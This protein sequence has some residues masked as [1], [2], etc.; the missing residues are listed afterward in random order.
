MNMPKSK[1][2]Q[3]HKTGWRCW[4]TFNP[5]TQETKVEVSLLLLGQSGLH[6]ELQGS[7][8]YTERLCFR[9]PKPQQKQKGCVKWLMGKV[10]AGKLCDLSSILGFRMVGENYFPQVV[11]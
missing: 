4:H 7:Q 10:P 6:C 5:S 9:K 2:N 11:I 8:G 1:T 3:K